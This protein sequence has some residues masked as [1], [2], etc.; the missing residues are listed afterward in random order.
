MENKKEMSIKKL[1]ALLLDTTITDK[2]KTIILNKI[3]KLKN[4]VDKSVTINK[5]YKSEE[6]LNLYLKV[7]DRLKIYKGDN[8]ETLLNIFNST[9][10]LINFDDLIKSIT[11]S[12]PNVTKFYNSMMRLL[13]VRNRVYLK[14]FLSLKCSN[15]ILDILNT[16]INK[17]N[18]K[19]IISRKLADEISLGMALIDI[20]RLRYSKNTMLEIKSYTNKHVIPIMLAF[21][22]NIKQ[23]DII[24]D[25][26]K[27]YKY[28][29]VNFLNLNKNIDENYIDRFIIFSSFDSN[30]NYTIT[31]NEMNTNLYNYY[32]NT[33]DVSEL[34]NKDNQF[35]NVF[36]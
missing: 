4:Q 21:M 18:G 28:Y 29:K 36:E 11:M 15:D 33:Y 2:A 12:G 34:C 20:I 14:K 26:F 31:Q 13:K 25:T 17:N 16:P 6:L 24:S 3:E 23:I 35:I 5:E 22:L 32:S 8:K 7:Q 30:F 1:E 10:N 9:R 27:D 19:Y